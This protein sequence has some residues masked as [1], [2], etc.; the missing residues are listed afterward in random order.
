VRWETR[1]ISSNL[2]TTDYLVCGLYGPWLF[3][4]IVGQ[5]VAVNCSAENSEVV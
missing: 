3:M 2:W 4:L 1:S 5:P